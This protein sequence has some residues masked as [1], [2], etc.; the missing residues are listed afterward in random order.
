MHNR[1]KFSALWASALMM[2][3]LIG[4]APGVTSVWA[5]SKALPPEEPQLEEKP[6][7]IK[8]PPGEK[9]KPTAVRCK[10]TRDCQKGQ[11][12]QKTGDHKE[13]V[14]PPVEVPVAPAT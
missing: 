6:G 7:Q 4:V 9:P 8:V 11:V 14:A 5:K 2:G 12:C 10:A 3:L 13:C 1:R